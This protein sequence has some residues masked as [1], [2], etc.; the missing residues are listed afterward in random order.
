MV[1]IQE[2]EVEPGTASASKQS[3]LFAKPCDSDI[4]DCVPITRPPAPLR[5]SNLMINER[6]IES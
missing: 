2:A 5:E 4:C 1:Q 6:S 3:V